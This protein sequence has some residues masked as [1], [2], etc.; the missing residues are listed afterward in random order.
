MTTKVLSL[1]A[2]V[3]IATS[4]EDTLVEKPLLYRCSNDPILQYIYKV[5]AQRKK[6]VLS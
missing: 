3:V 4:L 2:I 6:V 5:E 1:G